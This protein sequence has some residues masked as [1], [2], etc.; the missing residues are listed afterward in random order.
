MTNDLW[1]DLINSARSLADLK[2]VK[3]KLIEETEYYTIDIEGNTFMCCDQSQFVYRCKEHEEEQGCM[4]CEFVV[5]DSCNC[6]QYNGKLVAP[7]GKVRNM[8]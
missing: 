3:P 6:R 2:I 5:E 8:L 7:N 1:T 4:F